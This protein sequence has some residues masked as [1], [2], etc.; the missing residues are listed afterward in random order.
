LR[1]STSHFMMVWNTQSWI[2]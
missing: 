1:M 2:P